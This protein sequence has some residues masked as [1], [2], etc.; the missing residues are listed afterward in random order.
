MNLYEAIDNNL[1][2]AVKN[3]LKVIE[4]LC[5]EAQNSPES[6]LAKNVLALIDCGIDHA[7][8]PT[9]T[10]TLGDKTEDL[11]LPEAAK[12]EYQEYNWVSVS[13]YTVKEAL[14]TAGE[15]GDAEE[16]PILFSMSDDEIDALL[17]RCNI[18]D[19][20]IFNVDMDGLDLDELERLA[21]HYGYSSLARQA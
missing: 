18:K 20:N 2:E 12:P 11:D 8:R 14:D 3:E 5:V 13:V 21:E 19:Y 4:G 16:Y 9:A 7:L 17:Y 6:E 10:L 15:C 1:L